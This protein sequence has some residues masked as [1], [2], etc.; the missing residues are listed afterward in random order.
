MFSKKILIKKIGMHVIKALTAILF[1]IGIISFFSARIEKVGNSISEK[2][3]IAFVLAKRSETVSRLKKDFA[4]VGNA[5]ERINAALLS[6]DNIIPF[7]TAIETAAREEGISQSIRFGNPIPLSGATVSIARVDFDI[8]LNGDFKAL[9]RYL[10]RFETLPYLSGIQ[11][12]SIS[13]P[14]GL[15]KEESVTASAILYVKN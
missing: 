1:A 6:S 2:K 7:V 4:I 3:E 13:A 8:T 15:D 9:M 11:T 5:E 12:I 14:S 10:R